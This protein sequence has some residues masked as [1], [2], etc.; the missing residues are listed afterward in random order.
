[1]DKSVHSLTRNPTV[2]DVEELIF[3]WMRE[4]ETGSGL[5]THLALTSA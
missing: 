2:Q 4:G 5:Q 1:M 3:S